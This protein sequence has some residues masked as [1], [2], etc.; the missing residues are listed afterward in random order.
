MK[1]CPPVMK[2]AGLGLGM[3]AFCAATCFALSARV[4]AFL[5]GVDAA[6]NP[7]SANGRTGVGKAFKDV[8]SGLVVQFS[9]AVVINQFGAGE[10]ANAREPKFRI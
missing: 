2:R 7:S 1:L 9:A 6:G 10:I 8:E 5:D 4:P 3:V